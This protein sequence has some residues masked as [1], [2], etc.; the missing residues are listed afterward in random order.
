MIAH[1]AQMPPT[2]FSNWS[3]DAKYLV[4]LDS[5]N[6]LF[7]ASRSS[8]QSQ[9]INPTSTGTVSNLRWEPNDLLAFTWTTEESTTRSKTDIYTYTINTRSLDRP[10]SK[11]D[12]LSGITFSRFSFSPTMQYLALT[13]GS[14]YIVNQNTGHVSDITVN[15]GHLNAKDT[16]EK[17]Q[18][19]ISE[20][21]WHPQGDWL[22]TSNNESS[23]FVDVVNVDGTI[24]RELTMC[25]GRRLSSSVCFGW[26]PDVKV[27]N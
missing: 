23:Y 25:S 3:S 1:H 8:L 6:H 13:N 14:L 19:S 16:I 21:L 17:I 22:I 9:Q 5:A 10:L 15:A 20:L 27:L 7:I 26:M 18:G 2:D 4:F 12:K 11:I 24:Q